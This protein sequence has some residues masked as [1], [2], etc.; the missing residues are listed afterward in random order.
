MINRKLILG[1]PL[2]DKYAPIF[3][4]QRTQSINTKRQIMEYSYQKVECENHFPNYYEAKGTEDSNSTRSQWSKAKGML[5]L[6]NEIERYASHPA[7]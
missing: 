6:P 4:F 3:V 1:T 2:F 5:M 7:P